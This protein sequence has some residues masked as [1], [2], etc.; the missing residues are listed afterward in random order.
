MAPVPKPKPT[1]RQPHF[2]RQGERP[3]DRSGSIG[4]GGENGFILPLR[5]IPADRLDMAKK[6]QL[7]VVAWGTIWYDDAFGNERRTSY[8]FVYEGTQTDP[9]GLMRLGWKGNEET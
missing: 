8:R 5:D 9:P 3:K 6:G 1:N 2:I 4:P 7:P